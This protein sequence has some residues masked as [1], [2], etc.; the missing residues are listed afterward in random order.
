[1]RRRKSIAKPEPR[2]VKTPT[3]TAPSPRLRKVLLNII[4]LGLFTSCDRSTE[5]VSTNPESRLS[6]SPKELTPLAGCQ[7]SSDNP[8][9]MSS[10][11]AT[12]IDVT[13]SD[14]NVEPKV[15]LSGPP[16]SC[17]SSITFAV[18]ADRGALRF[19]R[20][21]VGLIDGY[22]ASGLKATRANGRAVELNGSDAAPSWQWLCSFGGVSKDT[23]S[24]LLDIA[25]QIPRHSSAPPAPSTDGGNVLDAGFDADTGPADASDAGPDAD[26]AQTRADASSSAWDAASSTTTSSTSSETET[27]DPVSGLETLF[28]ASKEPA[29]PTPVQLVQSRLITLRGCIALP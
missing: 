23:L 10:Y 7:P 21:Y 27:S 3:M 15:V 11:L 5:A 14:Q 28:E 4:A 26:I 22:T 29:T 9:H 12:L 2:W 24:D 13:E 1:M 18:S 8:S 6:L 16:T 19:D 25:A 17:T 20:V